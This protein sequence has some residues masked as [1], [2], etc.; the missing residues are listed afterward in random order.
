MILDSTISVEYVGIFSVAIGLHILKS[1]GD[2]IRIS[3]SGGDMSPVI[4]AYSWRSSADGN[5]AN[6]GRWHVLVCDC[7]MLRKFKL[8]N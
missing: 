2:K 8:K 3:N 6:G 7:H 1:G 5:M 4:N